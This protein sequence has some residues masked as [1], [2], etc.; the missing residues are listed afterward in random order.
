[1]PSS[2]IVRLCGRVG[3]GREHE[4]MCLTSVLFHKRG[5][6]N[7]MILI[8]EFSVWQR[9][10]IGYNCLDSL[11]DELS[12]LW[13]LNALSLQSNNFHTVPVS[14]LSGL[15]GLKT[16]YVDYQDRWQRDPNFK[17]ASP[18]LPILHP[19]LVYLSLRHNTPWDPVSLFHLGGAVAEV[20]D[21]DPMPT[22]VF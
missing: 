7:E 13:N 16:V 21:R 10:D 22:V 6:I 19:G 17:I 4:K 14:V 11:P 12:N 3:D 20:A 5:S 18:L 15:T 1:M 2:D 8:Q 9:L